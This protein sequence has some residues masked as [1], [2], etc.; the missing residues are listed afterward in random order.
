MDYK[1]LIEAYAAKGGDEKKMWA[2]VD[3]TSEAMDYLKEVAPEKHDCL[4]RKLHEVL[5]GKHYTE[6]MAIA[7][8]AKLRYTDATGVKRAGAHWT[9]EQIEAATKDKSYPAG[10]TKWDKFVAYNVM[11]ADLGRK[12]SDEHVLCAT[13]LFFFDDEDWKSD[14]KIWDYMSK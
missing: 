13:Y 14:G 10:T 5:Y 6:E 8:V 1:K 4:M 3:V 9:L 2:S 11:A 12:F 7:D